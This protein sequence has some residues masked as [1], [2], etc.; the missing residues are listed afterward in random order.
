MEC[1]TASKQK[2]KEYQ[3][4][5]SPKIQS[6]NIQYEYWRIF[7]RYPT[8]LDGKRNTAL[9]HKVSNDL[10]VSIDNATFKKPLLA[11]WH[12]IDT[13]HETSHTRVDSDALKIATKKA[14]SR[15]LRWAA[16]LAAKESPTVKTLAT[17]ASWPSPACLR[18]C[19]NPAK[20]V[21]HIFQ[22]HKG[23]KTWEN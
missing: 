11:C 20:K 7:T 1:D 18:D 13:L 9:G 12:K 14:P 19:G 6:H 16:R 22:C 15:Q 10:K 8:A 4:V 17:R 21:P 3:K 23:Y 5:G 2:C